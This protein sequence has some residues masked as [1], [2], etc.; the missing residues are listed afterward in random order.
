MS[1]TTLD[2]VFLRVAEGTADFASR[3]QLLD[4]NGNSGEQVMT[5][6]M[7]RDENLSSSMISSLIKGEPKKVD[8][9]EDF[10]VLGFE[11]ICCCD[12]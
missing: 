10:S 7:Q 11:G 4:A 6:S 9:E 5:Q 1:V 2:E 3:K 8:S 12:S